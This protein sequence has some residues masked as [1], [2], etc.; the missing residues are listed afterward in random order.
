LVTAAPLILA[1]AWTLGA[2]GH[3]LEDAQRDFRVWKRAWAK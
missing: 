1:V 2:V 3:V